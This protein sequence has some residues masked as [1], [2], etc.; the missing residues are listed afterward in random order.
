MGVAALDPTAPAADSGADLVRGAAVGRYLVLELIGSGGMGVVYA[1]YDPTLHRRIAL[2]LVRDRHGDGAERLLREAQALAQVSHP[3]VVAV[4]DVGTFGDRVFLAMELIDGMTLAEWQQPRLH[5][6]AIVDAYLQAGR[7]LIAAHDKGLLHRDFKPGNVLISSDGRVRVVD[8]G[9]ARNVEEAEPFERLASPDLTTPPRGREALT[10]SGTVLGTPA[11]MAP[12]QVHGRADARSDQYGFC[13]SLFEALHGRLHFEA[14]NGRRRALPAR[15]ARAVER[16]LSDDPDQRF[17][18]MRALLDALNPRRR[19]SRRVAALA[20]VLAAA[21]ALVGSLGMVRERRSPC[22]G[23]EHRL[24]GVWDESRRHAA[25]SAFAKSGQPWAGD[26]FRFVDETISRYQRD[27]TA[28]QSDACEATRVRGEQSEE[29]LDLRMACLDERRAELAAYAELI[30]RG[31]G[32]VTE[33]AAQTVQALPDLSRC[34]DAAALRLGAP[35]HSESRARLAE[36]RGRLAQ[37][38]SYLLLGAYRDSQPIAE[39]VAAEA[40]ALREPALEADALLLLGTLARR[41]DDAPLAQQKLLAALAAAERGRNDEAAAGAWIELIGVYG[42]LLAEYDRAEQAAALAQATLDRLGERPALRARLL[43]N[44][45]AVQYRQGRHDAAL[46][47]LK[48]ASALSGTSGDEQ[49]RILTQ[50]ALVESARGDD[51]AALAA[52]EKALLLAERMVGPSH[53]SIGVALSN[54]GRTLARLGDYRHARERLERARQIDEHAFGP[55]GRAVAFPLYNLGDVELSL[56]HLDE[57]LLDF[58]RAFEIFRKAAGPAHPLLAYPLTG[59]GEVALAQRRPAEA[60]LPLES[61]LALRQRQADDP[62]ER[63][64]TQFALA[65]A[66]RAVGRD[67]ERARRLAESARDGYRALGATRRQ[68]LDRVVAWLQR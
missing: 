25:Q 8:F 62:A 32:G 59:I 3:N 68:S 21:A 31:E 57:A 16:G 34:A 46:A 1:A 49:T 2:K 54:I 24:A 15:I 53:E 36:Q 64:R 40:G 4:L 39:A 61:A 6:R 5:W 38:R 44:F 33:R 9:L 41:R 45:A 37:G 13:A 26:L 20:W 56:G 28:M 51:R 12:E 18:S 22:G 55:S 10:R 66:L 48:Q 30:A 43:V 50:L 27:W 29:L 17:P 35:L 63:A 65:Q 67:R 47:S 14:Q 52:Q 7:G 23:A 42:E 11:Y 58:R 19:G 60:I